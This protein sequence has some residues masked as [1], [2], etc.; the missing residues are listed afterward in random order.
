MSWCGEFG[1]MSNLLVLMMNRFFYLF[2][3]NDE[4]ILSEYCEV[5]Y[6]VSYVVRIKLS[7]GN[8]YKLYFK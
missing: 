6:E 7:C 5:N 1:I 4:L 2:S 8:D 3:L